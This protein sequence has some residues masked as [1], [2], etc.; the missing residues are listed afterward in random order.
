[1]YNV[2]DIRRLL[3]SKYQNNEFV[4]DKTGQKTIELVGTSFL[5]D[6]E[7]IFGE[8]NR[9]YM[10]KEIFWYHSLSTNINDIYSNKEP[11]KAWQYSAD[12]YGNINSNYGKLIFSPIYFS[13]YAEAVFELQTN[14]DSRRATMVYNRPSI[15]EEYKENGK[16]DFICTNAVNYVI[17]D[18]KLHA[19]VQ[20]RSCDVVF[21]YRNDRYWQDHV[22]NMMCDD[23]E[24]DKGNIYWQTSSLHVYERHF[25]MIEDYLK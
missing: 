4:M 24:V 23:L 7:S 2:K 3:A 19:T 5:A 17:R 9:D 20:M 13:Q 12:E 11:P 6:E 14:R 15:W 25:N 22:L 21:G 16:N 8:L 10:E 1:M 18:D